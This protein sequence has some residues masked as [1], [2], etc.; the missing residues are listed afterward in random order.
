MI[1][2]KNILLIYVRENVLLTLKL[3]IIFYTNYSTFEKFIFCSEVE[4]L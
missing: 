2:F 4:V 3:I 1:L